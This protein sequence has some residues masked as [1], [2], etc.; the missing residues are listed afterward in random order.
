MSK[1]TTIYSNYFNSFNKTK[2]IIFS[3]QL[4]VI[5]AILQ[6]AG[7]LMPGVG[8]LISPLTTLPIVLASLISARTGILTYLTTF[9]LLVVLQP[10]ETTIFPFTTG[11]LGLALGTTLTS[12][13]KFSSVLISSVVLLTGISVLLY[14]LQFPVLGP[15]ASS[16]FNY[17]V[18][19]FIGIF[20]FVY[21]WFWLEISL[22]VLRKINSVIIHS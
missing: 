20:S 13:N 1:D 14:I 22:F 10:S 16:T 15:M 8:Y 19:V 7:G 12:Y 11:M 6:S 5:A 17:N 3:A 18:V 4:S 9:F 21:A 2:V